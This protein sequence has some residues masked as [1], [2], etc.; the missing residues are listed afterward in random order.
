MEQLLANPYLP[1][2]L[3]T[4]AIIL[5]FPLIAGY[6]VL[7]ERKVLAD[8]QVRLG[9]MRVGPYGVLQPLADALKLMLKEDIIPSRSDK[10]IFWLAP[11]LSTFTA[12]SAF[13]VL[14]LSDRL[15]VADVNIG[16]LF[17]LAM[18]S[19]GALGL[20]LGGWSANSKYSLM[21]SLR[22]AAQ[23]V[24]YEVP[25][26]FATVTAIMCAGTLSMQGVIRA[27]LERG[28]WGAFDNYGLMLIPT[29][30]FIIAATAPLFAAFLSKL[31]LRESVARRTIVASVLC[32]I[33]LAVIFVDS[34]S[35]AHLSGDLVAL[36]YAA[37]VAGSVTAMRAS[38]ARDLPKAFSLG[39]ACSAVVA[40]P[41]VVP[42][43]LG[44]R[45]AVLLA[46]TGAV[47]L[48]I[49]FLAVARAT[50]T[51]PAPVVALVLL[52]ETLIAPLLVW[53]WIGEQPTVAVL[54]AGTYL[55][56]VLVGHSV[57]G[58]GGEDHLEITRRAPAGS[59]AP[60]RPQEP[61]ST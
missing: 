44:V 46:L 38:D 37:L 59:P 24:S 40:L 30:L 28:V 3:L 29:V 33:G 5:V 2:L 21:G 12:L 6:I 49:A 32:V 36:A 31:F 60:D 55:L 56:A 4:V 22:A 57:A 1:P 19:I 10:W 48:P 61:R 34:V 26:G 50:E 20:I 7:A 51:L 8:L 15:Y 43:N 11:V 52:L 54:L 39:S 9:P 18:S 25:L 16:V 17:I 14:P 58:R 53:L 27:Q 47:L 13:A 42:W 23:M 35:T 45:D 41:F